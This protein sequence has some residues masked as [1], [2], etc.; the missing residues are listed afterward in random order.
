MWIYI[1]WKYGLEEKNDLAKE[2]PKKVKELTK[3][4]AQGGKNVNV[5]N[6]QSK[7]WNYQ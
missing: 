1:I 6:C 3:K 7:S 5:Q 4:L 2:M